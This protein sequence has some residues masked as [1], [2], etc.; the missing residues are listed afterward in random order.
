M[1][2][3][4]QLHKRLRALLKHCFINQSCSV[5]SLHFAEKT[6]LRTY[7]LDPLVAKAIG[8]NLMSLLPNPSCA[9]LALVNKEKQFPFIPR[10]SCFFTNNKHDSCILN[11]KFSNPLSI[12]ST[13]IFN[14]ISLKFLVSN[15]F[16]YS[17]HLIKSHFFH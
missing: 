16:Y 4:F 9:L 13:Y 3:F 10:T 2:P 17:L 11:F 8:C 14:H 6:C 5:F 1:K 7:P 12:Y 15:S